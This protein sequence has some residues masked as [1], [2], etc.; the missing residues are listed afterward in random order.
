M[1]LLQIYDDVRL[2]VE[3]NKTNSNLN[4]DI[5][6][7]VIYFNLAKTR[8]QTYF[9]EKRNEDAIRLMAPYLLLNISLTEVSD[10]GL[11]QTFELPDDY[12]EYSNILIYASTEECKDKIITG[13]EIKSE[14]IHQY[15]NDEFTRPSF[16]FRETVYLMSQNGLTIYTDNTFTITEAKLNYYKKIKDVELEGYIKD[17]GEPSQNIDTD[18]TDNL[19]P[20]MVNAIV[21]LFTQ[22]QGDI[23]SYQ[24]A[25]NELFS[26]I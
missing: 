20:Y 25:N 7:F 19:R 6:R 18:I 9:L 17:N 24:I 13:H 14:N 10:E 8:L 21:K 16:P 12:F 4:L 5:S 3:K 15:L 23:N 1:K 22:S 2:L 11:F 26:P